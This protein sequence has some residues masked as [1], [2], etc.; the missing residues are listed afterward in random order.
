MHDGSGLFLSAEHSV[1]VSCQ[2]QLLLELLL[3]FSVEISLLKIFVP[4]WA[5]MEKFSQFLKVPKP[6]S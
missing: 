3:L 1:Q 4:F 6:I 5:F 2:L